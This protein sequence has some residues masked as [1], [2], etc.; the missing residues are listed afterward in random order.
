MGGIRDAEIISFTGTKFI[1]TYDSLGRITKILGDK[2]AN[3]KILIDEADKLVD[4]GSFRGD[5]IR[6]VLDNYKKYKA[7][8]FMTATPIPDKYQLP[9]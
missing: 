7:Y 9:C 4:S 5:A 3:Y 6:T 8:T 2:V 1:T